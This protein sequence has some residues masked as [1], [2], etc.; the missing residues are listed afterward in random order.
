[1]MSSTEGRLYRTITHQDRR[2]W[3]VLFVQTGWYSLV[4]LY[5]HC[6]D[7]YRLW[8]MH[9]C[10]PFLHWNLNRLKATMFYKIIKS[11]GKGWFEHRLQKWSAKINTLPQ[12]QYTS[13][14]PGR[15]D[16]PD[17]VKISNKETSINTHCQ[18]YRGQKLISLCQAIAAGTGYASSASIPHNAGYHSWLLS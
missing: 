1:M 6:S 15:E 14:V 10:A 9:F 2:G 8:T 4:L 3:F 13:N 11:N 7:S 5:S 16:T 18:G 17:V 12:L